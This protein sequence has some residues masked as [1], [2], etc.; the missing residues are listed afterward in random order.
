MT[1]SAPPRL[2]EARLLLA[3][4]ARTVLRVAS[5]DAIVSEHAPG[6]ND[7]AQT[8]TR[9]TAGPDAVE[10]EWTH[11]GQAVDVYENGQRLDI[12]I[13]ITD[14]LIGAENWMDRSAP[15]EIARVMPQL[16]EALD[17]DSVQTDRLALPWNA[18]DGRWQAAGRM[19]S[20]L[21]RMHPGVEVGISQERGRVH[22]KANG[23]NG[24]HPSQ[25]AL[26]QVSSLPPM[27]FVSWQDLASPQALAK[28]R[29]FGT[30]PMGRAEVRRSALKWRFASDSAPVA[31]CLKSATTLLRPAVSL[32][33]MASVEPRS[34]F[35]WRLE[36]FEGIDML[37]G[38]TPEVRA[39]LIKAVR[40][41]GSTAIWAPRLVKQG[42]RWT[43]MGVPVADRFQ[44]TSEE[45]TLLIRAGYFRTMPAHH[46]ET[47]IATVNYHDVLIAV[48]GSGYQSLDHV[49]RIARKE[50]VPEGIAHPDLCSGSSVGLGM[51]RSTPFGVEPDVEVRHSQW[52]CGDHPTTPREDEFIDVAVA[53]D[54]LYPDHGGIV[55]RDGVFE[56]AIDPS[57]DDR[58]LEG[59][60]ADLYRLP[61]VD[62]VLLAR[63][64][65]SRRMLD[66]IWPEDSWFTD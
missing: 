50:L 63:Y 52:P 59:K 11:D 56:T 65:A 12:G 3:R 53:E 62:R 30:P 17:R 21:A 35:T 33:S 14:V 9:H 22:L 61:C 44:L 43:D 34:R 58:N 18:D 47:Y 19:A 54:Y 45:L 16:L 20:E 39:A 26:D 37:A 51:A 6:R 36:H 57:R 5:S 13:V 28:R 31:E 25:Q 23:R 7:D 46:R 49:R 8:R 38:E 41:N 27:A 55:I 29:T 10:V 48:G 15:T 2:D 1:H 40:V 66:G 42:A 24:E 60:L 4:L 64:I 32:V